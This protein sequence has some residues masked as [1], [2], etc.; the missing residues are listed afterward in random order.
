LWPSRISSGTPDFVFIGE[1]EGADENRR[2]FENVFLTQANKELADA[3]AKH[4]AGGF[5]KAVSLV[6]IPPKNRYVVI[7]FDSMDA[8]QKWWEGPAGAF[9]RENIKK[10]AMGPHLIAANGVQE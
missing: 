1:V 9:E 4:I 6:G 3:G 8:L 2:D 7:Q 5:D 10:Y